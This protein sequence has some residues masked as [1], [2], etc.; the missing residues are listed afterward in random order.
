MSWFGV[1]MLRNDASTSSR[2]GQNW[3]TAPRKVGPSQTLV[4]VSFWNARSVSSRVTPK[5]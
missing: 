1:T 2:L 4:L 3:L 5:T